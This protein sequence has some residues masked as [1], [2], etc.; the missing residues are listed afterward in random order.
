MSSLEHTPTP[1]VID[2][3][4]PSEVQTP[5]LNTICSAWHEHAEGKTITVNGIHPA[6]LKESAANAAFI[7]K[8]VNAHAKL[9]EALERLTI[10]YRD[11]EDGDG[12]PCPDVAFACEALALAKSE[13]K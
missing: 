4:Y 13:G 11:F 10:S 3:Q 8:A 7:V 9:V 1:W 6:S 5:D 2:P 12:N